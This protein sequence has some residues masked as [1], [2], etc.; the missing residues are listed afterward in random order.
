MI[1]ALA[2]LVDPTANAQER[3][4]A[5]HAVGDDAARRGSAALAALA[6]QVE[7]A[8][9]P[10]MCAA[11]AAA[12]RAG[13]ESADA[14]I[15]DFDPETSRELRE[16]FR[17]ESEENLD[18]ALAVLDEV[19]AGE[20]ASA[21]PTGREGVAVDAVF[22]RVHTLKGS[23]ATI[24][25]R[26]LA[27]AAHACEERLAAWRGGGAALAPDALRGAL[28]V[29]RAMVRTTALPAQA[30]E[31][32]LARTRSLIAGAGTAPPIRGARTR[33]GPLDG[34]AAAS[35]R[36]AGERRDDERL[37]LRVP[38]ESMDELMDLVGETVVLR[39]RLERRVDELR[40]LGRDLAAS[41]ATL[42]GAAEVSPLSTE[43]QTE[44]AVIGRALDRTAATLLED[45]ESLRHA[46]SALQG[47]LQRLRMLS[48]RMLFGR[49]AGSIREIARELG[50][51]VEIDARGGD[52]ELDRALV[53]PVGE[54]LVH[55][56]RNAIAHGIE[57]VAERVARGKPARGL[58]R[59]DA[60][61]GGD[62]VYIE[63]CDDG[64][65]IDPDRIRASLVAAGTLDEA[66][67][68][69]R[70]DAEIL[71]HIFDAGF[72]TRVEA[73]AL[74]GRGVG[75]DAVRV[76]IGSVGGEVWVESAI[77]E[78][79]TFVI[80]LPLTTAII[81]ALLF[82]MGG[83]V[84]AVPAASVVETALVDVEAADRADR[85]EPVRVRE[86]AMPL[87][88]LRPLLGGDRPP[89]GLPRGPIVVLRH[90]E[91]EFAVTCHKIVGMR[92]IVMR[93][94]GPLLGR[95]PLYAGATLSGAGKVQ[96]VLDVAT[97]A[98]LAFGVT[99]RAPTPP[100]QPSLGRVLLADDSRVVREAVT[101]LLAQAGYAVE[102]VT[103]GWEAW[104]RLQERA[105][106]VLVTDLEMPR[107]HGYELIG[108]CR[109]DPALRGL[110]ILVLTSRT[111][112]ANRA[113][114]LGAGASGFCAKPLERKQFLQL[115]AGVIGKA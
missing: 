95:L 76:A 31:A 58:L 38:A 9:D 61:Q 19:G 70:P 25:L 115:V 30:A 71:A 42:R 60:R 28:D 62:F 73:D 99:R 17:Q 16:L 82:K 68:R 44:L 77:E 39:T 29:L 86:R 110:P 102:T 24:G 88:R 113:R 35:D 15:G 10:P 11:L 7:A 83:Q 92:E 112:D 45:A 65:G 52:A 90:G 23:A 89:G 79:T 33:T 106:D 56:V 41:R 75:L 105:F 55:L 103:D 78:G 67:A 22:R 14:P 59:L 36:R 72:S 107:V 66:D 111:A 37:T 54:V 47:R 4:E 46:S 85:G 20:A 100:P 53:G 13:E 2:R 6:V 8:P 40:G 5:A 69:A 43:V 1:D 26:A 84:Y 18:A 27:E 101:A 12:A 104:E 87:L 98:D 96:L 51:D 21:R 50:K 64:A 3:A 114:A 108:K 63:V 97:L 93:S 81:Q 80:R 94:L 109:A 34:V 91:R 74:A 32:L 57:P 49:V 48:V